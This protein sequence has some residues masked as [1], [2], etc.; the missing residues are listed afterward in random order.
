MGILWDSLALTGLCLVAAG[1]WLAW[2]PLALVVVG[3][4]TVSLALWGARLW[5]KPPRKTG[6]W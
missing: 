4:M 1:L 3:L 6:E 5:S 2:P